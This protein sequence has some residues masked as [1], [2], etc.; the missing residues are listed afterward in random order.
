MF[1]GDHQ[2]QFPASLDEIKQYFGSESSDNLTNL[3]HFEI[4]YHG[5]L[6]NVSNS[7]SAIVVR[8]LQPWTAAGKFSKAYGF[9]DGH[10][11]IHSDPTG[12]FD[13]WERDHTAVLKNP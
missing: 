7:D 1:A 6:D 9:A 8:S 5:T 4:V 13:A 3:S 11:E 12:S 2:N 10:A